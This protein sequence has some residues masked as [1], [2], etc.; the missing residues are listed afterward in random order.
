MPEAFDP[1]GT[2]SYTKDQARVPQ[3]VGALVPMTNF[4]ERFLGS[5]LAPRI[6]SASGL[7]SSLS[8]MSPMTG[9]PRRG[10]SDQYSGPGEA[11]FLSWFQ[12]HVVP[13]AGQALAGVPMP[14]LRPRGPIPTAMP[15]FQEATSPQQQRARRPMTEITV[16]P[17]G[18]ALQP[19][20]P[21]GGSRY[22]YTSTPTRTSYTTQRG[23][24][25]DI[26][27]SGTNLV[28]GGSTPTSFSGMTGYGW[29]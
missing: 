22:K 17:L 1:F 15:A 12:R 26:P 13:Q 16:R 2:R 4:S 25:W 24:T 19:I 3:P 20:G 18:Q 6:A 27:K 28:T 8:T 10:P 14:N 29:S 7:P 5:A 9:V 11:D 23:K 21:S